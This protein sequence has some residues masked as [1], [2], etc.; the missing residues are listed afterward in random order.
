M[1]I[2][3]SASP[4]SA[5]AAA[6]SQQLV[7]TTGRTPWR[8]ANSV[9][10]QFAV[11]TDSVVATV[12]L[13]TDADV[14]R[15][16]IS[17]G[18]G[19]SN[20]RVISSVPV[21]AQTPLSSAPLPAGTFRFQ[22]AYDPPSPRFGQPFT[23]LIIVGIQQRGG[24]QEFSSLMATMTPR[25]R[26]N[27][28]ETYIN[29]AEPADP[30]GSTAEFEITMF[31]DNQEVGSAHWNPLQ[32]GI[33]GDGLIGGTFIPIGG[34]AVAHEFEVGL[35]VLSCHF[36]FIESDDWSSDDEAR[37]IQSLSVAITDVADLSLSNR[38]FSETRRKSIEGAGTIKIRYDRDV[39]LLVPLTPG[40]GGP[41]VQVVARA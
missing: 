4:A 36:W 35:D 9:I 19:T 8:A 39:T 22:H 12:D 16:T 5:A 27:H 26:V 20:T 14:R 37:S 30:F 6:P 25:Y 34:S 31:V 32:A 23:R 40:A 29:L 2:G 13:V 15:I 17:W 11:T 38:R 24:L 33:F 18:D 28:Y 10:Q 21:D 3:S 7:L 41:V 1:S